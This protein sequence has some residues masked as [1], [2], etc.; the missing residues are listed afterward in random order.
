M[1]FKHITLFG[2]ITMLGGNDNVS[3]NILICILIVENIWWNIVSP[4]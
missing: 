4:T 3:W 2:F 1:Y